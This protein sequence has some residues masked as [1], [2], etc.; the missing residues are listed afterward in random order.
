M[1]V[2]GPRVA[3]IGG[4]GF[5][6]QSLMEE[7]Q[8]ITVNTRYGSVILQQGRCQGQEVYFLARHGTSHTVPPHM[9][10]YRANIAALRHLGVDA[11]IA[12][13]SVGTLRREIAPGSRVLIDQFIDFTRNRPSSFFDGSGG[14]VVHVDLTEPYCPEVRAA[15]RRAAAAC[16]QEIIDGG[17]YVCTAGPRF[18]TPA[19]IKMMAGWGGDLVGMTNVPEVVLARE[20][21]LCYATI[22]LVSNYAAGISAAPLSHQEVL[23]EMARRKGALDRLLLEAAG[24]IAA[25]RTCKCSPGALKLE[26]ITDEKP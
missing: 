11:V 24:G 17:C 4:T 20:A 25:K 19:E 22:T 26:D 10:N 2:A 1:P 13:A 16:S 15:I 21:G 18:E 12:T 3:F 7:P 5:Y 8:T 9:V 6:S 23:D 14:R